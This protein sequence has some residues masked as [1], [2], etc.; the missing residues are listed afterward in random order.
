MEILGY[1]AQL[2]K[3]YVNGKYIIEG[4]TGFPDH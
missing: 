3:K 1:A 2:E 4:Y